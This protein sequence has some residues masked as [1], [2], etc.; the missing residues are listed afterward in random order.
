MCVAGS[1]PAPEGIALP[2]HM[3]SQIKWHIFL[4]HLPLHAQV[5]LRER[6]TSPCT[7]TVGYKVR[8]LLQPFF[9][10]G[11]LG[12]TGYSNGASLP[13]HVCVYKHAPEHELM[14]CS[15]GMRGPRSSLG[16]SSG[17]QL[18]G[19]APQPSVARRLSCE[20]GGEGCC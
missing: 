7:I 1:E 17:E 20:S 14:Y 18:Q 16:C 11:L 6:L 19:A 9:Y 3:H 12:A 2:T 10:I 15:A 13:M 8:R 4:Q 5:E